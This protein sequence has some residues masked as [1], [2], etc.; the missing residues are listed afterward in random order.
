[1]KRWLHLTILVLLIILTTVLTYPH[2][3]D[4]LLTD[5][6]QFA[7]TARTIL[8]TGF[9]YTYFYHHLKPYLSHPPT[10]SYLLSS[11]IPHLGDI[12]GRILG[13]ILLLITLAGVYILT[14]R[15]YDNP[16]ISLT[17]IFLIITTPLTLPV[18]TLLDMDG[19]ILP[20]FLII[21]CI[22]FTKSYKRETVPLFLTS[23][24][25]AL[26]FLTKL[27]T[28]ITLFP[29]L[30]L[31]LFYRKQRHITGKLMIASITGMITAV[32]SLLI[33]YLAFGMNPFG[34]VSIL[35]FKASAFPSPGTILKDFISLILWINPVLFLVLLW[36]GYRV[37][38][39]DHS[40]ERRFLFILGLIIT[41]G[42]TVINGIAY[43]LP[44]YQ[45]A[46]V[47]LLIISSG[48]IIYEKLK[49][50]WKKARFILIFTSIMSLLFSIVACGDYL[51]PFFTANERLVLGLVERGEVLSELM[52]RTGLYLIPLLVIGYLYFRYRKWMVRVAIAML[53]GLLLGQ[54]IMM[55]TGDY[56]VRYNY[57]E[58][59]I[60][61]VSELVE[62]RGE[63]K[64]LICPKD[65]SYH[66][67]F[68][69]EF[70]DTTY[71]LKQDLQ[72]DPILK[73]EPTLFIIRGGYIIHRPYGERLEEIRPYLEKASF[74]MTVGFFI[75][76]ELE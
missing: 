65:V 9:P 49:H 2:L 1:M 62:D 46:G 70:I 73:G 47:M 10:Y 66:N 48:D 5:E 45:M 61:L 22:A 28:P 21:V 29:A 14:R 31:M 63:N 55:A 75:I 37:F 44:K 19:T 69:Y 25:T 18:S 60:E 6:I 51:H 74:R 50:L 64:A 8:K 12:S 57:G 7:T 43:G 34:P 3:K 58:K 76:Y 27:I 72:D 17:V 42:Y 23:V 52:T 56:S 15:L 33:Y 67:D 24:L 20:L 54:S 41:I 53:I 35:I 39:T 13:F 30:L 71:Y 11:V 26:L 38:T 59:G 16:N 40:P 32:L 68:K 36:C 4:P